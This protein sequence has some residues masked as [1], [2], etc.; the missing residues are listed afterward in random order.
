MAMNKTPEQV[1]EWLKNQPWARKFVQTMRDSHTPRKIAVQVVNGELGALTIAAGF[2]W[3][4]SPQG[5]KY[6]HEKHKELIEWY[7]G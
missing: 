2:S 5:L 3:E 1:S 7:Y 4:D 6:W